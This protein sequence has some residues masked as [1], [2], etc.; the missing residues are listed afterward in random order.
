VSGWVGGW[1]CPDNSGDWT[2]LWFVAAA[3][4]PE[5]CLVLT[6]YF[7]THCEDLPSGHLFMTPIWFSWDLKVSL[8]IAMLPI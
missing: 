4:R 8:A 2:R 6:E 7:M 1:S 5:Q 3:R